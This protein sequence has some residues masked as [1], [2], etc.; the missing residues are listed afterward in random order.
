MDDKLQ[1]IGLRVPNGLQETE[2]DRVIYI[3]GKILRLSTDDIN[4]LTDVYLTHLNDRS[5]EEKHN[6][7]RTWEFVWSLEPN[8]AVW[9]AWHTLG[10]HLTKPPLWIDANNL[11][12]A[13]NALNGTFHGIFYRDRI[14]E[15]TYDFLVRN[16]VEAFDEDP[17]D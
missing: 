1:Q 14:D 16:W 9:V 3:T 17:L 15:S 6:G 12:V 5:D 11:H 8:D 2:V 10:N 13:L 7:Y 4:H